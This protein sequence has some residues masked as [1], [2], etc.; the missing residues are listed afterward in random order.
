[1]SQSI[2]KLSFMYSRGFP[3][4]WPYTPWYRRIPIKPHLLRS[5]TSRSLNILFLVNDGYAVQPLM[6]LVNVAR[7]ALSQS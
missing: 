6:H 4:Y 1:M 3:E 7:N 5:F 2:P